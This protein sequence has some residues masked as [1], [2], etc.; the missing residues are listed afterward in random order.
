MTANPIV[1]MQTNHGDVVIE[2]YEKDVPIHAAN[3]LKLVDE[4][5]YDSLTFHRVVPNFV[6]QGGDPDGTGMGGAPGKL[7][8][9]ASS[10]Y[11]HDR[12]TIAMARS[13][14]GA[15][16][17]QFYI[18]LKENFFLDKQGFLIFAKVIEGMETMDKIATVKRGAQDR[19]VEPVIMTKVARK[20]AEE[21]AEE[22]PE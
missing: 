3:F 11:K 10:P 22:K 8:D 15:S 1:L 13:G 21:K 14:A 9:D 6:I 17:S 16:T 18:N 7:E 2:V 19:P 5:F 4:G 20:S 12:T